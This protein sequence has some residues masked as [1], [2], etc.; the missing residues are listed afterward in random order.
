MRF[1]FKLRRADIGF[2]E[3]E[4]SNIFEAIRKKTI[5][6]CVHNLT[7]PPDVHVCT[8]FRTAGKTEA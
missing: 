4:Q 6:K 3:T 8:L 1:G 5:P 7:R 2:G